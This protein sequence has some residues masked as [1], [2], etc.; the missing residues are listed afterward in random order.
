MLVGPTA[1]GKTGVAHVLA[2]RHRLR[3]VSADAMMVYCGMDIGTAKPT[4]GERAAF[5]YAG[6]DLTTPDQS[7]SA[8]DYL[9][10]V[11][12]QMPAESD[13]AVVGGSGLYVK[14]LAK[15]LD[16]S[17]GSDPAWREEAE[18]CLRDEGFEALQQRCRAR[19]PTIDEELPEGD[20]GNPRRWI[21]WVE[22]AD[23]GTVATPPVFPGGAWRLV[24]IRRSK[25]D[26]QDR[27]EQRVDAMLASGL[28][29]EVM[30]L[31]ERYE[32]FSPTAEKAI[33]Y[34]EAMAMLNNTMTRSEARERI[35]IRTRQYAKRQM[36]WF[37]HQLPAQWIDATPH[38][39]D[40]TLA[41]RV[42]EAWSEHG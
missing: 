11:S 17:A 21:R 30:A 1:A 34:A 5:H 38:D 37:R 41:D 2:R 3:L 42:E 19:C 13:C 27:I 15:G 7:F 40:E 31:R 8:H 26:L 23:A 14:A 28:A 18:S 32:T 22:R 10:E 20:R 36:T 39:D 29:D 4:P 35:I 16:A 12:A 24:G 25:E 33:G 9:R 6:L